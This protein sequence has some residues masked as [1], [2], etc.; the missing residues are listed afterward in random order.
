MDWFKCLFCLDIL[1]D[2]ELVCAANCDHYIHEWC[3]VAMKEMGE[4]HCKICKKN[5]IVHSVFK[6]FDLERAVQIRGV[7]L[8]IQKLD[9]LIGLM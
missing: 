7:P 6:E 9:E 5:I 3:V 1:K 2:S 4:R 8:M